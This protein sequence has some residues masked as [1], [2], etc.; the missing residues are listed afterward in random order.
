MDLQLPD[1][2]LRP[3]VANR[4]QHR[5]REAELFHGFIE[6]KALPGERTASPDGKSRVIGKKDAVYQWTKQVYELH[7]QPPPSAPLSLNSRIKVEEYLHLKPSR[8]ARS[9][10]AAAG[11]SPSEQTPPAQSQAPAQS[12]EAIE[13]TTAPKTEEEVDADSE[14]EESVDL[15]ELIDVASDEMVYSEEEHSGSHPCSV[16]PHDSDLDFIND[17]ELDYADSDAEE[18]DMAITDAV[19]TFVGGA[20]AAASSADNKL[21]CDVQDDLVGEA[22]ILSLEGTRKTEKALQAA[23]APFL[24]EHVESSLHNLRSR[25]AQLMLQSA[26]MS[27]LNSERRV[28]AAVKAADDDQ[29]HGKVLKLPSQHPTLH[30]LYQLCEPRID[31][32]KKGTIPE[33][34]KFE[35]PPPAATPTVWVAQREISLNAAKRRVVPTIQ[36][37]SE[38]NNTNDPPATPAGRLLPAPGTASVIIEEVDSDS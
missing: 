29:D 34:S 31:G 10:L 1:I 11:K 38:L 37:V 14:K 27:Q 12:Q 5:V 21:E 25:P 6:Y 13:A 3:Q 26:E 2:D 9:N 36:L 8:F 33:P 19:V 20:D 23:D 7:K 30:V 22:D 28:E 18:D 24:A 4:V 15:H 35:P 16:T 32:E 17:S